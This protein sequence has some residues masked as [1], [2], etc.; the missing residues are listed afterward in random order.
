VSI[1]KNPEREAVSPEG[2]AGGVGFTT[3]DAVAVPDTP[4]LSV[5]LKDAV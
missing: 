1:T 2:A 5:T 4:L 3:T